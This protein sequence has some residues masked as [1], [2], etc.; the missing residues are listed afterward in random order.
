[1]YPAGGG[2][3]IIASLRR[4]VQSFGVEIRAAQPVQSIL[5]EWDKIA[6][7]ELERGGQ[8]RA[9]IVVAANSAKKVFLDLIGPD[10]IGVDFQHCLSALKPRIASA[11]LMIDLKGAARDEETL[12]NMQRRLVYAP[13]S[14]ALRRAYAAARAGEVPEEFVL[15]AIFP[16]ILDDE[17]RSDD[18]HQMFVTAHPVPFKEKFND[19]WRATIEAAVRENLEI[20]SP[21]ISERISNIICR[22]P[23]DD[24]KATGEDAASFAARAGVFQ[25][26]ALSSIFARNFEIEGLFFCGA[27]SQIGTGVSCSAGR[28]AAQRAIKFARTVE[29]MS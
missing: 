20:F 8:I 23:A 9:P 2:E 27:E 12:S 4:A 19:D 25:Q 21:G 10:K 26:F 11:R 15:E 16:D 29:P 1:G 3:T 17:T 14:D 5:T 6:G 13:D 24:A 18:R 7:V 22:M 28:S